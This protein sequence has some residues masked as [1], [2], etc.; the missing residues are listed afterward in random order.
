MPWSSSIAQMMKGLESF[1]S[2]Q[3][4]NKKIVMFDVRF[5]ICNTCQVCLRKL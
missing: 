3:L 2:Y 1:G 4:E 5:A